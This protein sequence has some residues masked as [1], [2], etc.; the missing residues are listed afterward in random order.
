MARTPANGRDNKRIP[1]TYRFD[2]KTIEALDQ[3]V[4][5]YR[6]RKTTVTEG[7]LLKALG[8]LGINQPGTLNWRNL[9]HVGTPS[10][11][12]IRSTYDSRPKQSSEY[13]QT[14]NL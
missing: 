1:A 7:S 14:G 11:K 13:P 2:E 5:L 9:L 12:E 4:K 6:E 3:A 8:E 10:R